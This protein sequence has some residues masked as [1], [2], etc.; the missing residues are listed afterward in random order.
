[1]PFNNA[2][3]TT[4]VTLALN[5]VRELC[6]LKMEKTEKVMVDYLDTVVIIL[7]N[8]TASSAYLLVE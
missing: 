2:V 3:S 5:Q 1:M 8:D 7:Y 6:P 4:E